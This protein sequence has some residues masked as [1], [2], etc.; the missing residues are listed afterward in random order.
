[1]AALDEAIADR[2]T[3][4]TE[5]SAKP[6]LAGYGIPVSREAPA[7]R[8]ALAAIPVRCGQAMARPH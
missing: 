6:Y 1:M 3:A 5:H 2:Q 7:N 4:L 8:A